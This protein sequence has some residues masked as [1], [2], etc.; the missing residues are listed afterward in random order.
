MGTKIKA[1]A[2]ALLMSLNLVDQALAHVVSGGGGGGGGASATAPEF[3]APGGVAAIVLLV[4][5]GAILFR[6]RK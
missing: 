2:T 6:A 1:S 5:I 4:S 3:D